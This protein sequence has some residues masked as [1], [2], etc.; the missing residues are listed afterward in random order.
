MLG[1]GTFRPSAETSAR[2]SS[3]HARCRPAPPQ[4]SRLAATTLKAGNTN[5]T[6]GA[7]FSPGCVS[8]LAPHG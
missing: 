3:M 8:W 7:S 5:S 1:V 2:Q 6:A 4:P